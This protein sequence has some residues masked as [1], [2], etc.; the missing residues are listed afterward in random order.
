MYPKRFV[1]TLPLPIGERI[2]M[3]DTLDPG[4]DLGTLGRIAMKCYHLYS[5][6]G[7]LFKE[8]FPPHMQSFVQSKDTEGRRLPKFVFIGGSASIFLNRP[9]MVSFNITVDADTGIMESQAEYHV[10][11]KPIPN[12]GPP[13]GLSILAV[14][15]ELQRARSETP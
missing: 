12:E 2:N 6:D 11:F 15:L 4:F 13:E 9:L 8:E 10:D 5:H 1:S 7:Q 14:I 3:K